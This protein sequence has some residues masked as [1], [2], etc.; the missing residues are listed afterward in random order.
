MIGT[1]LTVGLSGLVGFPVTAETDISNALPAFEIIGLPD[2][3]VKEAKD[4]VRSGIKNCGFEFPARRIVVNLAPANLK[5]EGSHFDLPIALSVLLA[6]GQIQREWL[7][8]YIFLGELSLGGELRGVSG[9]LPSILEMQ[10]AGYTKF[11][12]PLANAS[13]GA[14]AEGA[15]VFGAATLTDCVLHISGEKELLPAENHGEEI[16]RHAE[17]DCDFSEVKGQENIKRAMV[18]AAAGGHNLL[19]IGTPGSGKSMLAKR[20]PTILPKLS[21]QEALEVT[22]VYSVAGLLSEKQPLVTTRPFRSPH[23]NVS[24]VSLVGGGTNPKPGEVSLAHHGVLFLDELPEFPRSAVEALRQPM[25]DGEVTISRVQGKNTYPCRM[26]VLAAMNPCPCGYYGDGTDR[27]K[28][29]A[30]SIR[31]YVSRISGPLLDRIDM[32]V[33]ASPVPFGDL[34]LPPAES[35]EKLREQVERARSIQQERYAKES[36]SCNADLSEAG[37]SRYCALGEAEEKVMQGVFERMGL[38]ARAYSRILKVARTIADLEGREN[39][40]SYDLAEA[41]SYREL[42]RKFFS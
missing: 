22:K 34:K 11:I 29:S 2:A 28:C 5:K 13:E 15:E 3:A 27:C 23:H 39:I 20:F 4:R 1:A 26:M 21:M 12:V 10:K 6:S 33:E 9:V 24:S 41:V 37:L 35:S 17:Y 8:G 18:I 14:L 25:E 32:E 19:M 36:Y 31:R 40:N 42:D 7:E 16:F 38:S 30:S